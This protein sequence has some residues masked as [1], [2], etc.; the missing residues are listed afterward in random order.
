[1]AE[2]ETII[3]KNDFTPYETLQLWKAL[4][5]WT[6]HLKWRIISG[7]ECR[8]GVDFLQSI[9]YKCLHGGWFWNREIKPWKSASM[10]TIQ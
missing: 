10:T 7:L 1:V 5:L 6:D 9:C 4:G 8:V 3:Y 2:E